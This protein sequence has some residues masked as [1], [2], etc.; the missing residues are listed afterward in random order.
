MKASAKPVSAATRA[1]LDEMRTDAKP[2][3]DKLDRL[4]SEIAKLRDLEFESAMLAERQKTIGINVKQIKEKTLVDLFDEAGCSSL[5]ID[6]DGN[7]PPYEVEVGEY[8][9]ANIPVEQQG[10][11]YEYLKSKKSEDLIKS[12]YTI[13]FGLRESKQAERFQ[14]SLDKADIVYSLK[15]GVP[16]NTLTA[17]F[18]V[19]H[20]KKPLTAKAMAL[21][22]A[23][24]GRVAKVVKQKEK[25]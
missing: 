16:W 7:L 15:Q 19:E 10:P 1:L 11:A 4:R 9:H 21:L 2:K 23:T 14:R 18:K 20:K 24:V 3:G 5:G 25:K 6:A 12:T 22:G 17:W 8:Y 13:E